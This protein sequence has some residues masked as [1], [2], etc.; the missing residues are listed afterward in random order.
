MSVPTIT[1]APAIPMTFSQYT[2]ASCGRSSIAARGVNNDPEAL[3]VASF[4][5]LASVRLESTE[6]CDDCL[7]RLFEQIADRRAAVDLFDGG[8][9]SITF[10]QRRGRSVTSYVG[11]LGERTISQHHEGYVNPE[12]LWDG[13]N[14]DAVITRVEFDDRVCVEASVTPEGAEPM[15]FTGDSVRAVVA[16]IE[17]AID[18]Y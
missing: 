16:A 1:L 17:S 3:P 11:R 2:C 18:N 10:E 15:N 12:V 8:T 7:E 4:V 14:R 9:F 6:F 13:Y 5:T